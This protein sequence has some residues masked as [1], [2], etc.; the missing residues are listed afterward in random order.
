MGFISCV[1]TTGIRSDNMNGASIN[2]AFVFGWIAALLPARFENYERI[3]KF[4]SITK[5]VD[6]HNFIRKMSWDVAR[7]EVEITV[8]LLKYLSLL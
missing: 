4:R 3:E 7:A 6:F 1:I 8:Y 5:L 2:F